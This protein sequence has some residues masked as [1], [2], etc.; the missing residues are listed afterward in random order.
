MHVN[1]KKVLIIAVPIIGVG[2]ALVLLNKKKKVPTT[3][4]AM[5]GTSST[6]KLKSSSTT[7]NSSFPLKQ[8]SN[9][10]YV[11]QLQQAL[12]IPVDGIFGPQTLNALQSK[13]GK[14]TVA[15]QNDLNMII[16]QATSNQFDAAA[17]NR[18]LALS[19]TNS[20]SLG[21]Y[22]MKINS[23]YLADQVTEERDT[24]NMLPTGM[25]MQLVGGVTYNNV[26]YTL[27]GAT[28]LGY[29]IINVNHGDLFGE[30]LIDPTIVS[31]VP[32]AGQTQSSPT[33]LPYTDPSTGLTAF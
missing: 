6:A 5:D 24:G 32:V 19:L 16:K 22:N 20:Y 3:P 12:L 18:G 11:K 21:G 25:A 15:T 7:G 10:G 4:Q 26:D 33:G 29:L 2:V 13:Y 30:Y 27:N 9:N 8:G 31:L 17:A 1:W 14:T 23:D 28:E